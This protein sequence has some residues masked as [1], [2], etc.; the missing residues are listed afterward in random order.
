MYVIIIIVSILLV[1]FIASCANES[2]FFTQIRCK[3]LVADGREG[4]KYMEMEMGIGG[5]ADEEIDIMCKKFISLIY[6]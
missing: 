4:R 6:K 3:G 1:C 2:V 5:S